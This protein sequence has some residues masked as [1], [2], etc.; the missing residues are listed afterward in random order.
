M[1]QKRFVF[2]QKTNDW[3][4][5]F[6]SFS[7]LLFDLISLS[8]WMLCVCSVWYFG[9]KF[10]PRQHVSVLITLDSLLLLWRILYEMNNMNWDM[11]ILCWATS[12]YLFIVWR[13][14]NSCD[15]QFSLANKNN[16]QRNKYC[17]YELVCCIEIELTHLVQKHIQ[18]RLCLLSNVRSNVQANCRY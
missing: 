10:T 18:L 9:P 13:I 8:H 4:Q 7:V 12:T 5:S 14:K 16:S 15:G 11:Q 17:A 6:R 3:L 1:I 2:T